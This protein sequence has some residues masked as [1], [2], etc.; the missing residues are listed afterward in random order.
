[1]ES[2]QAANELSAA[3]A[4][5]GFEVENNLSG[6]GDFAT[7]LQ[8]LTNT[9]DETT[10]ALIKQG[11]N[12]GVSA[13]QAD[14]LAASALGL[15][16]SLGIG[17]SSAMAL[18]AKEVLVGKSA[19]EKSI[20]ALKGVTDQNERLAIISEKSGIGIDQLRAAAEANTGTW[21]RFKMNLGDVSENISKMVIPAFLWMVDI[22]DDGI[23]WFN[24]LTASIY[25]FGIQGIEGSN[26]VS[27]AFAALTDFFK[28][29]MSTIGSAIEGVI[30]AVLNWDLTIESAA[31]H[32]AYWVDYVGST[33]SWLW[34]NIKEGAKFAADFLIYA[35][36]TDVQILKNIL[37]NIGELFKET[38]DFISSGFTDAIE[39]T[40]SGLMDG[41]KEFQGGFNPQ[42]FIDPQGYDE[43][44]ADIE[45]R[46]AKRAEKWQSIMDKNSRESADTNAQELDKRLAGL[47]IQA[48]DN[49]LKKDK[50][51]KKGE[52]SSTGNSF[53]VEDILN[54][55]QGSLDKRAE[56]LA[57]EQLAEQKKSTALQA[58]MVAGILALAGTGAESIF[59]PRA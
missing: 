32:I 15:E 25:E 40:F 56:K 28:G 2:E 24:G 21:A 53:A 34:G 4:T 36:Q 43:V 50:K 58:E 26:V 6:F 54:N 9:S 27:G 20:P 13:E 31:T 52:K 22:L 18:L 19:L 12:L 14:E 47:D 29:A 51:E 39:P 46:L 49:R 55:L 11:I 1:M 38:W 59:V 42:K 3:L 23:R 7:A 16:K 41:V 5:N 57:E 44:F 37:G 30:F 48:E 17:A 45:G 35:F 10:L 33:F 8:T